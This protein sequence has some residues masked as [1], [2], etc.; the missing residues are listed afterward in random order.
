M[1][2]YFILLLSVLSLY[3]CK[4]KNDKTLITKKKFY[5]YTKTLNKLYDYYH[6]DNNNFNNVLFKKNRKLK[7][8][9]IQ[10]YQLL[11]DTIITKSYDYELPFGYMNM[12]KIDTSFFVLHS[13]IHTMGKKKTKDIITK[14][15]NRFQKSNELSLNVEKYPSAKS[16]IIQNNTDFIYVTNGFKYEQ[17]EKIYLRKYNSQLKLR[18]EK[19]FTSEAL[20]KIYA[21]IFIHIVNEKIL[22]ISDISSYE[23]KRKVYEILKLD[24]DFNVLWKKEIGIDR[25]IEKVVNLKRSN[26]L[27]II[28]GN[29]NENMSFYNYEGELIDTKKNPNQTFIDLRINGNVFYSINEVKKNGNI[30]R[31]LC[32]LDTLGNTIKSKS[33]TSNKQQIVFYNN[34]SYVF[35]LQGKKLKITPLLFD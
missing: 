3:S 16:F 15:N 28:H 11:A 2:T 17:K 25:K 22:I 13:D 9:Q 1:K 30:Y 33:F 4:E 20:R 35:E 8:N 34:N 6:F 19:I 31:I 24:I 26:K 12:I 32:K 5:P 18:K 27:A 10:F 21:P 7:D 23:S 14:Y 29:K